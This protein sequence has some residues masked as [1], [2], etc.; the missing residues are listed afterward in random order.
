MSYT[1]NVQNPT[2]I[3]DPVANQREAGLEG[4]PHILGCLE[5]RGIL[6]QKE[7]SCLSGIFLGNNLTESMPPLRPCTRLRRCHGQGQC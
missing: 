2:C 3:D 5:N 7:G 4:M 1:R 6:R